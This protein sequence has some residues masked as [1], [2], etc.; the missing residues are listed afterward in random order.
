MRRS[1]I[2]LVVL[3]ALAAAQPAAAAAPGDDPAA[4]LTPTQALDNGLTKSCVTA[5]KPGVFGQYGARGYYIA[6]C[7]VRLACPSSRRGCT[8]L[9]ES[10]INTEQARG[11]WVTLN[12]RTRIFRRSGAVRGFGDRSCAGVDSCSIEDTYKLNISG[13]ESAS[14]QCNGVRRAALNR[15]RVRCTVELGYLER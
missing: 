3:S 2:T 6:G 12:S 9:A 10:R 4:T 5:H 11:H 1:I 14:V 13:G 8:I 15:A 7:T